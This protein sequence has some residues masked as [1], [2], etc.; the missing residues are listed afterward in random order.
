MGRNFAPELAQAPDQMPVREPY[1]CLKQLELRRES[2]CEADRE[3]LVVVGLGRKPSHAPESL[4]RIECLEQIDKN[5]FPVRALTHQFR[6]QCERS[7]TV[8]ASRIE[9]NQRD[10]LVLTSCVENTRRKRRL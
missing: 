8:P 7:R 1:R 9:I 2:R 3:T 10:A 6:L 4:I 5:Y